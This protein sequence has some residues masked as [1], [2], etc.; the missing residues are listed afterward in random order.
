MY[1]EL[2]DGLTNFQIG[3]IIL[4]IICV[5]LFTYCYIRTLILIVK[6]WF[7]KGELI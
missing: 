3:I 6:S 4:D 7:N 5:I 1:N 2:I